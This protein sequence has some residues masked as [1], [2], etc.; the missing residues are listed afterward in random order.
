MRC[1]DGTRASQADHGRFDLFNE[2]YLVGRAFHPI[3]DLNLS[4]E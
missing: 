2:R 3:I 4:I 1:R